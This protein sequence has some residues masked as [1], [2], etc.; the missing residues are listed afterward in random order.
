MEPSLL[1]R[2]HNGPYIL[3]F[4]KSLNNFLL[5]CKRSPILPISVAC[6]GLDLEGISG[7][8]KLKR[9]YKLSGPGSVSHS[10]YINDA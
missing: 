4:L 3:R 6:R 9:M 7:F 10:S 8:R 1:T 2:L 5:W